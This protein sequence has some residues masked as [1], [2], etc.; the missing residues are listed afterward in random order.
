MTTT[1]TPLFA[2]LSSGAVGKKVVWNKKLKKFS[3]DSYVFRTAKSVFEIVKYF[4][5][6]FKDDRKCTRTLLGLHVY[7]KNVFPDATRYELAYDV[8]ILAAH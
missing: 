1:T 6:E 8:M 4:H 5:L 7:E 3:T 2:C